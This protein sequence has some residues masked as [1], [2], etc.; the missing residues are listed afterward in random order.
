M[1]GRFLLYLY[2]L[3]FIGSGVFFLGMAVEGFKTVEMF[4]SQCYAWFINFVLTGVAGWL[5]KIRITLL[6]QKNEARNLWALKNPGEGTIC[7]SAHQWEQT[8]KLKDGELKRMRQGVGEGQVRALPYVVNSL[9]TAYKEDFGWI[10]DGTEFTLPMQ[11]PR[12]MRMTV[13]TI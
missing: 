3:V 7:L 13:M 1:K 12:G 10:L 2:F 4:F 5:G 6:N 8:L 11:M 9:Q